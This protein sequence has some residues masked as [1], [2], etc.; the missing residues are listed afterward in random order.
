[1]KWIAG[2]VLLSVVEVYFAFYGAPEFIP[3]GLFA[4]LSGVTT[5]FAGI[6]RM[7]AQKEFEDADQ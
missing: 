1:M 4:G 3:P 2:A 5:V 7:R 6:F